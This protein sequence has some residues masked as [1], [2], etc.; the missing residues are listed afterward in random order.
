MGYFYFEYVNLRKTYVFNLFRIEAL[1]IAVKTF[2]Y[3]WL[4]DTYRPLCRVYTIFIAFIALCT[5]ARFPSTNKANDDDRMFL[6][7]L[8]YLHNYLLFIHR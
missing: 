4:H 6:I 2:L 3:Q 5:V 7:L 1:Q 8:V